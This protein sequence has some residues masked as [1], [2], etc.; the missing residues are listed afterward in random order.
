[1]EVL[2]RC[3][4]AELGKRNIRVN[5]VLPG[6]VETEGV[7]GPQFQAAFQRI[8]D[9]SLPRTPLGRVGQ[10]RDIAPV[11]AFLAS[12]DAAWITGE[13]IQAAGGLN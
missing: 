8:L 10:P 12:D 11:V 13:I 9:R 3:L 4:A 7:Q 2:T 6:P 1:V 5:A